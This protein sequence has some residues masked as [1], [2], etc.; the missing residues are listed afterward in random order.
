MGLMPDF[1]FPNKKT[2]LKSLRKPAHLKTGN[3]A[4][5]NLGSKLIQFANTFS[6]YY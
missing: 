3:K 2:G 5:G 1:A 6:N 4:T